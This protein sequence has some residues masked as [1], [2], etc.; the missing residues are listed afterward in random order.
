MRVVGRRPETI[1]RRKQYSAERILDA[2]HRL[3]ALMHS[4]KYSS[5]KR[6]LVYSLD[7]NWR[8]AQQMKLC[9]VTGVPFDFGPPPPGLTRNPWAPSLDRRDSAKGYTPE[10]VQIVCWA[11]NA[12]KAEWSEDVLLKLARAIVDANLKTGV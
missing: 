10:N 12:A 2:R 5:A 1:E 7:E 9:A 6:G 4:A 11:Y 8:A 3:R